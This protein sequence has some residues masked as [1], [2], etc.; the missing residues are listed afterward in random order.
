[1]KSESKRLSD[2]VLLTVLVLLAGF[3]ARLRAQSQ[4]ILQQGMQGYVGCEDAHILI[5]KPTHNTGA[6]EGLELTGNGWCS[7][8]K[9][10]WSVSTLH[11]SRT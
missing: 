1:M 7:D 5:D 11:L 10:D 8:A 4:I 3:C 6:A 2:L 9:P